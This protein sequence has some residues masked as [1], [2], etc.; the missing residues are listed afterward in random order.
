MKYIV[1]IEHERKR[2]VQCLSSLFIH[3]NNV[4]K[5]F[6]LSSSYKKKHHIEKRH[7]HR[8]QSEAITMTEQKL[9]NTRIFIQRQDVFD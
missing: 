8:D 5:L 7:T 6:K 9:K 3:V 4:L 1:Y 2:W